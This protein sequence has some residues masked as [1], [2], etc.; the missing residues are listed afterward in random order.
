MLEYGAGVVEAK[1]NGGLDL[2][3]NAAVLENPLWAHEAACPATVFSFPIRWGRI[4]WHIQFSLAP[5]RLP[6]SAV[7]SS[8]R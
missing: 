1:R 6:L 7:K 4:V 3:K 2:L 5:V 8:H